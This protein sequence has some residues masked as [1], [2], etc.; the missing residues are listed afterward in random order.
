MKD[1]RH[2]L[3]TILGINCAFL[4]ALK[5]ARYRNPS[6]NLSDKNIVEGSPESY[7]SHRPALVT[8]DKDDDDDGDD[9]DSSND[10]S[11]DGALLYL[12]L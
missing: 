11:D 2:Q 6:L 5:A 10:D 3:S 4:V 7:Q 1:D 12:C 9:D 8:D